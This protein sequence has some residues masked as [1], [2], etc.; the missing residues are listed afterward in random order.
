VK[1]DPNNHGALVRQVAIL[2]RRG[3]FEQSA[4]AAHARW[5]WCRT[6]P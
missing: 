6:M 4:V 1:L 3:K 2:N 5:R